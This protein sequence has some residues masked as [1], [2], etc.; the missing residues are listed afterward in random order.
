M[1]TLTHATKPVKEK[2]IKREWKLIDLSGKIV[3]RIAPTI[4]TMLQGKNKV[5]YVSYLDMGDI[6]VAINAKKAIISGKKSQTKQ[7]TRF[8]GYPGGLKRIS[9]QT[10]LEKHPTEIIKHAVS[11]MLPKN[12]LR[13][14]RLK[15][16]YIFADDKHPYGEKFGK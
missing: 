1:T 16:L 14:L 6:V 2:E 10:M 11:G 4:A 15:R 3:G 7:Y 13:N 8:S 5:N 12:K 9:Y